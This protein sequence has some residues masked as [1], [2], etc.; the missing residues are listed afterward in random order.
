[1]RK[2]PAQP[3]D[4]VPSMLTS[5]RFIL[6]V[7]CLA[8]VLNLAQSSFAR[9]DG[10]AAGQKGNVEV[11]SVGQMARADAALLSAHR[12]E[13]AA[14]AQF[15]GYDLSSGTWIQSQVTCPY[16]SAYLI[17]H[18]LQ[19]SHEGAVSL[20]TALV[21]RAGGHVHIIPVLQHGTQALRVFGSTDAQR[22]LID[23]VVS[24]REVTTLTNQNGDW[25]T[26]AYCYGALTGAEPMPASAT[27]ADETVP[28]LAIGDDGRVRELSFSI[29]GPDHF[30][31]DWTIQFD[32]NADVKTIRFVARAVRPPSDV[33][34]RSD[35][36]FRP[37][38]ESREPTARVV[39]MPQ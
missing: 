4:T 21:P 24:A 2:G 35:S 22:Q 1:M 37:V 10:Q 12:G 7:G 17:V 29:L 25:T 30:L 19:L 11:L 18:N 33:P 5:T 6:A 28:R 38:P 34:Q 36:P 26:L 16:V 3:P 31:Q 13:I 20:F 23:E 9:T 27:T 39:P 8:G 15:H 14:A 32:H